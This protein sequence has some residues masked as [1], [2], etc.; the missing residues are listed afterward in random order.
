MTFVVAVGLSTSSLYVSPV[1]RPARHVVNS[2]SKLSSIVCSLSMNALHS[3]RVT[4]V[5]SLAVFATVWAQYVSAAVNVVLSNSV[6]GIPLP[7]KSF[8]KKSYIHRAGFV[9]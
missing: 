5:L 3:Y 9:L 8:D 6:C 4:A 2:S 1:I 7:Y